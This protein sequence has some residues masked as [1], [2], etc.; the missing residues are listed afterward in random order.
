MIHNNCLGLVFANMH[1]EFLGE[2]TSKRTTG[3]VPFGG[4]YRFI[5]FA[6]SNLVNSGITT[7]G[8]ITRHNYASLMDH[9]GSGRSWDLARKRGGLVML[10]PYGRPG[11]GV[12]NSRLEALCNAAG[13]LSTRSEEYVVMT[14]T[15]VLASI[16]LSDVFKHHQSTGADVT[17]VYKEQKMPKE[18]GRYRVLETKDGRVTDI[19]INPKTEKDVKLVLAVTVMSRKAVLELCDETISRGLQDMVKDYLRKNVDTLNIQAYEFKGYAEFVTSQKS[20]YDA[21]MK[22]LCDENR[23]GLFVEGKPVYT[24]VRDDF[25]AS[26]GIDSK[27]KNSIIA[28]GCIIEGTV[29]NSVLFRGVT[30]GKGAV[31]KDSVLMQGTTIGEN[32]SVAFAITD[33]NV[34]VS[35]NKAVSG[36]K[37]YPIY[38]AKGKKV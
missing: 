33:K 18:P 30:V 3:S 9:L 26:Y 22:L 8:V 1:D 24:K 13:F 5:D 19:L 27:V 17:L 15:N 7:V 34:A 11:T 29:E 12:Y 36:T 2:M 25:P 20:Y 16:D 37:E 35:E 28:D 21:N 6:L 4:R 32:S 23:D 14:D 10:P 31:V 38:F